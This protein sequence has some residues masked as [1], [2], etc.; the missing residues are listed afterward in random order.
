MQILESEAFKKNVVKLASG[1]FI[2][3]I[4]T[5]LAAPIITRLY[6]AEN[7]GIVLIFTSIS[8]IFIPLASM[9]YE[10][11]IV[12]PRKKSEA[13]N[14]L[15]LSIVIT[16]FFSVLFFLV[17]LFLGNELFAFFNIKNLIPYKWLI[18][19]T[20]FLAGIT[21]SC[22]YWCTRFKYFSHISVAQIIT[23][24]V[25]TIG[26]ISIGFLGFNVSITLIVVGIIG[27]LINLIILLSKIINLNEIKFMFFSV[28][29][30]NLIEGAIRYKDF[31]KYSSLGA[32]LN[33]ASWQSPI[34]ILAFY[35]P[36]SIVG[37]YG[38]GFRLI[39]MPMS[40]LGN[41]INQVFLQHGSKSKHEGN[42]GSD[43][44]K[45][46]IIL[47]SLGLMPSLILMT[48]GANLFELFFGLQWREAG[49]YVQI[50]APWA[51]LWFLSSPLSPVYSI[52]EK[53]KKELKMHG[54]IFFMRII[55]LLLGGLCGNA[56]V[57]I[58]LFSL[59]GIV[60]YAYLLLQVFLIS[61]IDL[62]ILFRKIFYENFKTF[63]YVLPLIVL[64]FFFN[65]DPLL[66]GSGFLIF[67]IVSYQKYNDLKNQKYV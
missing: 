4:I 1:T 20:F 17:I 50:L 13:T 23:Q 31:P 64:K 58:L 30:K 29:F 3:Q 52:L 5:L 28:K 56:R 38:L 19:I 48:L 67:V 66:L 61:K 49:V 40:L 44:E 24:L 27:Q 42:L 63:F 2:S 33:T 15:I 55:S 11:S 26:G 59:G 21:S 51:F 22:N 18:P 14:L 6:G 10:L 12:L 53:Q 45:L 54:L 39:Q 60:A 32:L 62:K 41:A 47:F 34:I 36:V 16:L 9:R 57:A 7:Y 8:T 43:I 37:F 25:V 65:N 35:F 46:F